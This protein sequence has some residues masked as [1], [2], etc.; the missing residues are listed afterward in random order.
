MNL[1]YRTRE[2]FPPQGLP[3]VLFTAHPSDYVPCLPRISDEILHLQNCAIYYDETPTAPWDVQELEAMLSGMQLLVIPV[4]ARF[5]REPNRTRE[6]ELPFALKHHIPVLPLLQEPGLENEF[7]DLCGDMQLLAREDVAAPVNVMAGQV[8]SYEEK[9]R[10]FL[11]S[12]LV[13][14]NTAELIRQEFDAYVFLSY[15]KKDR[16]EAQRLMKLIHENDFCRD[17]AVWYDE[18]LV[19]GENFTEGI[20]AALEKS[21]LFALNV[22]PNLLEEGNYVA[23]VEYP[24]AGESGKP[25][26]PVRMADTDEGRLREMYRGLPECVEPEGLPEALRRELEGAD[27]RK[28]DRD[29]MHN[30]LIGLAYL[31]GVDVEPDPARGLE[32]LEI[33]AEELPQAADKLSDMYYTGQGITRDCAE[34]HPAHTQWSQLLMIAAALSDPYR[35]SSWVRLCRITLTNIP[36]LRITEVRP[37]KSGTCAFVAKSSSMKR[38]GTF[39]L[40]SGR[41][42]AAATSP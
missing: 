42:S 23:T 22:T 40:P 33:A 6:T 20:R 3:K 19:P 14:D 2:N 28:N 38:T 1:T 41:A 26:L 4:T 27:L 35:L 30:Y 8:R 7:S 16:A 25:V 15:R 5:L 21:R 12:V 9:L 37:W 10:G 32:L 34:V 24:Q 31:N 29:P 18:F 17:V 36:R 11:D 39:K 13:S